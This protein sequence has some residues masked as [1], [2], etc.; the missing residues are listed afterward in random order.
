MLMCAFAITNMIQR[1]F[2]RKLKA[3]IR[4]CQQFWQNIFGLNV[5]KH[6]IVTDFSSVR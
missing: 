5:V 3:G 2:T 6:M 1:T 4:K